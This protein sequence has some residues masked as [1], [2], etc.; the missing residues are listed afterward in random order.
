MVVPVANPF[1]TEA[2]YA[3]GGGGQGVPWSVSL[4]AS[5]TTFAAGESVTLTAT[6]NQP[7]ASGGPYKIY[8]FDTTTGARVVKC[9]TGSTCSA[10]W[11][12]FNS[13]ALRD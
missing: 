7:L 10:T 5:K 2:A 11:V 6:S 4:V 8:I 9:T 12:P 1:S 13:G 3:N